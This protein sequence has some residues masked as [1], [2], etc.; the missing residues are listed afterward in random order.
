MQPRRYGPFPYQ[1]IGR[2][3]AWNWPNGARLALWVIPNLEIFHLDVPMPGDAQERPKP[4]DAV[5][6]VRQWAQRDYG[7]RVGIWRVMDVLERRGIRATAALN[8]D[9][10]LDMPEIVEACGSLNWEIIGHGK[11][12]SLRVNEV[13]PDREKILIRECL[14]TIEKATGKRPVGWLGSGLQ[15]SWHT[16]DNLIDNGCRYVA[17]WVNDDQPYP[18]DVDGRRIHSIPYPFELN[19][20][21]ALLRNKLSM[22]E[23]ER[24]IRDTFEVLY[25]EGEHAGRVMAISLHPFVIGH[26]HRI[27]TLDRALEWIMGHEGVWAATGSEILDAYLEA[28][29]G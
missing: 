19:D 21:A 2:R 20:S 24:M 8:S 5:P 14:D 22:P 26:P 9:I 3:K 29:G 27:P 17:D 1:P 16:L 23:F 13:P 4:G 10:C 6:A 28:T 15:E 25:A 11:T 12:N 18:M 7:N